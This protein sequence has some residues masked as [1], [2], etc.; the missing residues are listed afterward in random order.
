MKRLAFTLVLLA[1]TCD[2]PRAVSM[3]CRVIL[4]RIVEIELREQGYLDP[5][6]ARQKKDQIA[7]RLQREL[8]A[9]I[10]RPLPPGAL[11]CVA[12]A[13]STESLSH[14]CLR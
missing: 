12:S 2:R 4:D 11:A 14:D 8:D 10:G 1:A 9:C 7:R 5:V 13:D 3:D 6:L